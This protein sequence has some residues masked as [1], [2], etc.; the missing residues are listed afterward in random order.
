M[1]RHPP[2]AR[3]SRRT[4]PPLREFRAR[5][6]PVARTGR[7]RSSDRRGS[8]AGS[9]TARSTSTPARDRCRI[10]TGN[11]CSPRRSEL[12]DSGSSTTCLP[13]PSRPRA[14]APTGRA[15]VRDE[16]CTSRRSRRRRSAPRPPGPAG[17]RPASWL[18]T[19][20]AMPCRCGSQSRFLNGL[21]SPG[22]VLSPE[23][24]AGCG[25][26]VKARIPLDQAGSGPC[27]APMD[28]EGLTAP[29]AAP[30]SL[31]VYSD[32]LVLGV[33]GRRLDVE[34]GVDD[35]E[36]VSEIGDGGRDPEVCDR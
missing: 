11:R 24:D 34:A 26:T 30:P 28:R 21:A 29:R 22:Q 2:P 18:R 36:P 7:R 20:S 13:H 27:I 5:C 6:P 14:T 10:R 16:A 4:Q 35:V 33:G 17:T 3:C 9:H 32:D 8:P 31:F 15:G 1:G 25:G 23:R 19:C 12:R